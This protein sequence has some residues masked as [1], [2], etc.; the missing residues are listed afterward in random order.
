MNISFFEYT[1]SFQN[2]NNE[3]PKETNP[4]L[5]YVHSDYSDDVGDC[6][7]LKRGDLVEIHQKHSSGWWLGRRLKDD[8]ILTWMPSAF[9]Q[10]VKASPS[11]TPTPSRSSLLSQDPITEISN[12]PSPH[13]HTMEEDSEQPN[14]STETI[15]Q[16]LGSSISTSPV[17]SRIIKKESSITHA[18]PSNESDEESTKISVRE[19]VKKFN[20]Q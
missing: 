17:Y 16:N 10:K 11:V 4:E 20:R 14:S 1:F 15:Y 2:D 6:V 5:Y 7:S 13:T 9:L 8:F 3:S 12:F 18:L 19:L